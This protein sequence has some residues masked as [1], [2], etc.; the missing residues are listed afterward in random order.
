MNG[1]QRCA[2]MLGFAVIL[3]MAL[4][5][6]WTITYVWKGPPVKLPMDRGGG[7]VAGPAYAYSFEYG[8]GHKW[9]PQYTRW[10]RL[11]EARWVK[12][13]DDEAEHYYQ[14]NTSLL[15]VQWF[16]VSAVTGIIVMFLGDR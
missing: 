3:L 13:T 2:V 15:L 5:P 9:L 11:G 4:Y 8:V 10:W 7:S 1:K 14:I 12:E 6:P 16:L